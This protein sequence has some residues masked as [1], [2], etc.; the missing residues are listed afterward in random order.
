MQARTIKNKEWLTEE[1]LE[2]I[3]QQ[4]STEN[5]DREEEEARVMIEVIDE[6]ALARI[7]QRSRACENHQ[8]I[9]E[10]IATRDE[11]SEE[12]RRLV[13]LITIKRAGLHTMREKL[14][15]IR[16]IDKKKMIE[17]LEKINQVVEHLQIRNIT[18]LNDTFYA[19]AAIVTQ[20]LVKNRTDKVEP[21]WK[22]RLKKKVEEIQKDLSRIKEAMNRRYNDRMR[23][24]TEQKFNIKRKG[25]QLVIEELKQR[26]TATAAKIKRFEDRVKQ[27]QQN[28][29]FENNQKRFYEEIQRKTGRVD[30]IPNE[31]ET[32]EFW[33]EIWGQIGRAS[34]R[35]RV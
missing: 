10:N 18:E 8:R 5:V 19:S 14:P 7:Y 1:E 30:E 9:S 27:Y 25:Y 16:H 20:K 29:L 2:E 17:E 3:K 4:E 6:A 28:R 21:P 26:L 12:S 32:E 22:I 31:E 13:E 23:R 35:E 11:L 34:C 33:K 15:N 24:K